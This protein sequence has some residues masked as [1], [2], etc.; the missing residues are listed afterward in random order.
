MA[1]EDWLTREIL[2]KFAK[3]KGVPDSTVTKLWLSLGEVQKRLES[4][5]HPRLV[6]ETIAAPHRP[7]T[8]DMQLTAAEMQAGVRISLASLQAA[9]A[10]LQPRPR[11][12]YQPA[13]HALLMRWLDSQS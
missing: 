6:V 13:G 2:M 7:W 1:R 8:S 9:R 10:Y 11:S 12:R 4:D 3:E 5:G